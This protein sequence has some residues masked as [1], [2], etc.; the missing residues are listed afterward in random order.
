MGTNCCINYSVVVICGGRVEITSR[1]VNS[2]LVGTRFS[3]ATASTAVA[4]GMPDLRQMT[5]V[6]QVVHFLRILVRCR[7][8]AVFRFFCSVPFKGRE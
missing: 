5:G 6:V 4:T 2:A 8:E 1:D 3:T 7:P